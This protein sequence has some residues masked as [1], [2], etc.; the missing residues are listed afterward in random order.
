MRAPTPSAKVSKEAESL[1]KA[2]ARM[3]ANDRA[4][5]ARKEATREQ[6]QRENS[7]IR[8]FRSFRLVKLTA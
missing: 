3:R 4:R 6:V 7:I 2:H 5:I 8:P 1:E